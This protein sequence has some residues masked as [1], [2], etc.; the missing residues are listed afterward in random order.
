MS[1][2]SRQET[3]LAL[4]NENS[5][6]TVQALSDMTFISPSSI[7]RDLAKLE[8]LSLVKRSRGGASAFNTGSQFVPLNSRMSKNVAEKR[9]I[10][11]LASTLLRDGQS[12]MLDGSSTAGHMVPHIAKHRNMTVFT[13][14]LNTAINA[15]HHGIPTHC[16]GGYSYERSAV[17]SGTQAFRAVSEIH[18]DVLFFSSHSL[19]DDGIISEPI[20]EENYIRQLM[21]DNAKLRVFLCDSE[22]FGHRALYQLTSVDAIDICVFDKPN[23]TLKTKS[24]ILV[25]S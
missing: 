14:N 24:K 19:S 25:P 2:S 8:A 22:K 17:L 4:L 7:R 6:L 1:L 21:I 15:I 16:T 11:R 10:A 20:S 13:N 23:P 12:I 5:F 18:P 9:K 3:I